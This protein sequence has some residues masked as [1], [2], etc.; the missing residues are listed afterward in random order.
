M[1]LLFWVN[2]RI[3]TV[4]IITLPAL[5]HMDQT[6]TMVLCSAVSGYTDKDYGGL[7]KTT[8]HCSTAVTLLIVN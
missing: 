7:V 5:G 6:R 8:Q 2:Y 3:A 1:Q 4:H